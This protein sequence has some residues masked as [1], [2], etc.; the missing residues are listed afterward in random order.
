MSITSAT[1]ATLA[2]PERPVDPVALTGYVTVVPWER[3]TSMDWASRH[4]DWRLSN[5][6]DTAVRIEAL[7]AALRTGTLEIFNTEQN[8]VCRRG[9]HRAGAEGC[10]LGDKA[11]TVL[12]DRRPES[13]RLRRQ[14]ALP[15]SA[16]RYVTLIQG[17]V[18]PRRRPFLH[19]MF[20]IEQGLN[21]LDRGR[22]HA[23]NVAAGAVLG[24]GPKTLGSARHAVAADP[25]AVAGYV[26][27]VQWERD[28]PDR[29]GNVDKQRRWGQP[30]RAGTPQDVAEVAPSPGGEQGDVGTRSRPVLPAPGTRD[31]DDPS[32]RRRPSQRP[33]RGHVQPLPLLTERSATALRKRPQTDVRSAWS[34]ASRTKRGL[35]RPGLPSVPA[36]RSHPQASPRSHPLTTAAPI[37]A[38]RGDRQEPVRH[39]RRPLGAVGSDASGSACRQTHPPRPT[40]CFSR[41]M[42]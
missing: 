41:R 9:V 39:K 4:V 2:E 14:A 17:E 5:T 24:F 42:S 12:L 11:H 18:K 31:D 16:H 30:R 25:V 23:R 36:A 28:P 26:T 21:E 7:E 32:S 10:R 6:M 3:N 37:R 20:A 38:Q 15:A 19:R 35:N 13:D 27:A 34:S 8:A 1:L 22:K 40:G 29:G 33:S